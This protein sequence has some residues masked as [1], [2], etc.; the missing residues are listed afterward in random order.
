MAA[1]STDGVGE[2]C[3]KGAEVM[4]RVITAASLASIA[5][6]CESEAPHDSEPPG[7]LEYDDSFARIYRL[8][9]RID[10]IG[11]KGDRE[12]HECG[13]LSER[14]HAELGDT[15][16]AL[17]PG[18]DYGRDPSP[19]GCAPGASIHIEGFVHS[20]FACDFECCRP[21]LARAA[22]VYFL[23]GMHFE[24]FDP[25]EFDGEPYIAIEPDTPCP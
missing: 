7:V 6:G 2:R 11:V 20:P 9:R 22:L 13:I 1:S 5:M 21:E 19:G 15:L 17:E 4:R 18:E 8:D 25:L 14:A 10:I 16:S 3:Y 12:R 23:I 24:G